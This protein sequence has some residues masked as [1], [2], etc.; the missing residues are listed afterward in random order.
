MLSQTMQEYI[1]S[2][3]WVG[4]T[5]QQIE[6]VLK[7]HGFQSPFTYGPVYAAWWGTE[8]DEALCFELCADDLWILFKNGKVA[9]VGTIYRE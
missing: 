3:A 1:K 7:A 5:K 8:Y 6:I 4:L 2:K 9:K